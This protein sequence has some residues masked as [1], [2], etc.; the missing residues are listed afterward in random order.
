MS[1]LPR[2]TYCAF[3]GH[4]RLFAED[5]MSLQSNGSFELDADSDMW[6]DDWPVV[7]DGRWMWEDGNH[8]LRLLS[9]EPGK[10]VML[11]QE[12][13]ISAKVQALQLNWKQRVSGLKVGKNSWFD[14]RIMLEFFDANRSKLLPSPQA[15][16]PTRTRMVG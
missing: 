5:Q 1:L 8:F 2:R 7:T 12:I 14:A 15:P 10:M 16:Q 3:T 13:R 4:A 11:Y 6:P 9:P